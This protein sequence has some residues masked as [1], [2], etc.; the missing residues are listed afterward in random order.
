MR[1]AYG[2][3]IVVAKL[4]DTLRDSE[5]GPDELEVAFGH[6]AVG[7]ADIGRGDL[8][9]VAMWVHSLAMGQGV[10][11][12]SDNESVIEEVRYALAVLEAREEEVKEGAWPRPRLVHWCD[13]HRPVIGRYLGQ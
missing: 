10:W 4:E 6:E 12:D 2:E 11:V 13:D 3:E 8:V 7:G 5:L 1:V 9:E